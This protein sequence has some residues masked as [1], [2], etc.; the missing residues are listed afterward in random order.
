[1]NFRLAEANPSDPEQWRTVI[2]GSDG[3]YLTGV[4]SYR[5][6]L[7]ISSRVDGLDQL[8][9]ALGADFILLGRAWAYALAAAGG[10][11]VAHIL[12]LID[13]EMR[14]VMALTGTRRIGE[15]DAEIVA[16]S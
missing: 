11:G 5:D 8:M 9:L 1:M 12:R 2:P 13:A 14:V 15:I 10:D 16:R 6:H 4:S 3:T 7:V